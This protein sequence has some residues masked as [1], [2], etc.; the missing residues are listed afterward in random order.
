M[1][2]RFSQETARLKQGMV[3]AGFGP[4]N[5]LTMRLLL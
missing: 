3:H 4:L 1:P 2:S 5:Q